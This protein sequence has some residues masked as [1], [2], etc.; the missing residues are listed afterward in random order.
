MSLRRRFFIFK[1]MNSFDQTVVKPK[2]LESPEAEDSI[3]LMF[4]RCQLP[5][6]HTLYPITKP[7]I[8]YCSTDKLKIREVQKLAH[9]YKIVASIFEHEPPSFIIPKPAVLCSVNILSKQSRQPASPTRKNSTSWQKLSS[10][11]TQAFSRADVSVL[12]PRDHWLLRPQSGPGM[13]PFWVLQKGNLLFERLHCNAL[14]GTAATEC[15]W[16][17]VCLSLVMDRRGEWHLLNQVVSSMWRN[18]EWE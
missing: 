9:S 11:L 6:S 3:Y 12:G 10:A 8:K 5:H 17:A 1:N 4:T 15:H 7:H 2:G 16:L 13:L 14:I 18:E